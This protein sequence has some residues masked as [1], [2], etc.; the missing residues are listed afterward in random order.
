MCR[1]NPCIYCVP[2]MGWEVGAAIALAH[3]DQFVTLTL[4]PETWAETQRCLQ[5]M[6][7]RMLRP[8]RWPVFQWAFTRSSPAMTCRTSTPGTTVSGCHDP[9]IGNKEALSS[10]LGLCPRFTGH[11]PPIVVLTARTCSLRLQSCRRPR[12]AHR[13]DDFLA[14]N[15][16]RLV[17]PSGT[18][19]R[20]HDGRP[21]G[22]A[23]ARRSGRSGPRP[24]S[25]SV[26][27]H[28]RR[29][30]SVR[31]KPGFEPRPGGGASA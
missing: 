20:D 15:H 11:A 12:L 17:H 28:P 25:T 7:Q 10:G 22:T 3:P 14:L 19:W 30:S 6:R 24:W 23:E 13:F 29:T 9:R 18:F 2:I 21:L 4:T 26:G 16:G 31:C 5:T 8:Q 1:V 27:G